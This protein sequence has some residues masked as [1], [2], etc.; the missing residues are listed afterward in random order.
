M[1]K[2]FVSYAPFTRGQNDINKMFIY[3]VI[4]L[5]LPAVFGCMFFGLNALFI[6]LLSVGFSCLF[7]FLFNALFWQKFKIDNC[8]CIITGLILGLTMPVKMPLYIVIFSAFVATFIT[9]LAFGGL[10]RNKFNPALV[11]RLFASMFASTIS[12][13]LYTLQLKGET[14]VSFTQGGTNSILNLLTG[15][16]VGNVGTTCTIIILVALVFLI[17][18]GVIDWKIPVVSV[19]AYVG[20]SYYLTGMENALLNVCSGSFLF[21]SVF[22]MTDPNV[23]PN[24]FLSKILYSILFGAL[25]AIV[26]KIGKLGEDTVFAVAL[27]VNILSPIMDKYLVVKSRPLG[28][29]RYARKN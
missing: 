25:C 19:I 4:A 24:S 20:V 3:T 7:E 14:Y 21:V 17:Y 10:G 16:A 9:K 18:M 28:G 26:W 2:F 12:S 29:Y 22:M 13:D 6:I 5:I 11:G 8:S 23:S 1:D 27:F 15:N